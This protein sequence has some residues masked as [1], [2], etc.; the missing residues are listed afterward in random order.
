[1]FYYIRRRSN[2]F[3]L[4]LDDRSLA[5]KKSCAQFSNII[6]LPTGILS[7]TRFFLFF[8][9]FRVEEKSMQCRSKFIHALMRMSDCER[10]KSRGLEP[11]KTIKLEW[12]FLRI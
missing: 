7:L 9:T 11:F 4:S 2:F 1:M 12:S 6:F 10:A 8:D 5:Q 3:F